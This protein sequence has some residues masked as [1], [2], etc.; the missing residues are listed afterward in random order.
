MHCV[1]LQINSFSVIY[2]L[3]HGKPNPKEIF[4]GLPDG[5]SRVPQTGSKGPLC[6]YY[7]INRLRTRI[8]S[9]HAE[10]YQKARQLEQRF[11]LWRKETTKAWQ[12]ERQGI[13]EVCLNSIKKE[14]D[15]WMK[16]LTSFL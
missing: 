1:T 13:N 7:A 6:T 12:D 15:I 16:S 11:S 14:I 8:G 2:E 3:P 4:N 5:R 10:E 9:L